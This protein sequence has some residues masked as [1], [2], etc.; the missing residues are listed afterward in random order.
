MLRLLR[1]RS[2][3]STAIKRAST[4]CDPNAPNPQPAVESRN[5]APIVL[6]DSSVNGFQKPDPVFETP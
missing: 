1:T 4:L 5:I 2:S 6:P 3:L